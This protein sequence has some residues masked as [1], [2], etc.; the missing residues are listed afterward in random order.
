MA[1]KQIS[2]YLDNKPGTL[3]KIIRNISDAGINIRALSLADTVEFG[4]L[5]LITEDVE[6]AEQ[7]L[8]AKT[9][10]KLSEVIAV[11]MD[12]QSGG[13]GAILDVLEEARINIEYMYA[14]AA[15]NQSAYAVFRVDDSQS[16]ENYLNAKG[17][18]TLQNDG[19]QTLLEVKQ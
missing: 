5:R 12:D 3:A 9:I 17:I 10:V 7:L 1:I 2:V 8:S 13:L 18:V 4:I 19:L 16:A 14:F 15:P 6:K 11:K